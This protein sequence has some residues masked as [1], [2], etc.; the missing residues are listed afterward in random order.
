[1]TVQF[2]KLINLLIV[3]FVF[4]YVI[5]GLL[6]YVHVFD[7]IELILESNYFVKTYILG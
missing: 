1:M 5:N 2:L 3:L 6:I 7:P 4:S